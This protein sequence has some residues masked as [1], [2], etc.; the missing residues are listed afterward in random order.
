MNISS[1]PFPLLCLT[2]KSILSHSYHTYSQRSP[3]GHHSHL[4]V[5]YNSAPS[6]TK[7][8]T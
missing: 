6:I 3:F 5:N 2:H 1:H 8:R 7:H 4:L